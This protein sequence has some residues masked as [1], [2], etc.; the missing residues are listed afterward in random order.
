[1]YKNVL[2]S[3]TCIKSGAPQGSLLGPLLFL[4]TM[5]VKHVSHNMLSFCRLFADD[6]CIQYASH[7]LSSIEH[8]ISHDLYILEQWSSRCMVT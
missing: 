5:Y 3:Y 6:N 2:S 1:M 4:Y 8:N 7:D